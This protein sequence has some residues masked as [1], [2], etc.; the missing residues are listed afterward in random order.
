MSERRLPDAVWFPGLSLGVVM[1]VTTAVLAFSQGATAER[2]AQ[3]LA[4]DT[5]IQLEQILPVGYADNNLLTDTLQLAGPDGAPLTVHRARKQGVLRALLFEMSGNGY[6]GRIGLLMAVDVDG[7]IVGVRVTKHNETPG[8]GDKIEVARHDWIRSF[9]G[10]SLQQPEPARWGVKKDG[11]VFDQFAGA[12]ITPRAVV[13]TVK[14]G[15]DFLA[16]HRAEL[17]DA[18]APAGGEKP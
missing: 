18:P 15:L 10:K 17:M 9:D 16:G 13:A 6:G 4:D 8:L 11:G 7:R 14:K 5:R 1:L 2:I 3:A 12:T